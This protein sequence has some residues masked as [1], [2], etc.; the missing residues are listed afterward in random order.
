LFRAT[1]TVSSSLTVADRDNEDPGLSETIS[2]ADP[3][4]RLIAYGIL[5]FF[6]TLAVESS[7][8]ALPDV[9]MEHRLYLPGFGASAVFATLLYLLVERFTGPS[10]GKLLIPVAIIL[11]MSFGFT[12]YQRNHVWRDRVSLWQDAAAKSPDRGRTNNNLGVAL[13]KAGRTSEAIKAFSRAIEVDPYYFRTY[14]NLADIYLAEGRPELS[15]PLL[16]VYMQL[17]PDLQQGYVMYGAALMRSG[18]FPAVISFLEQNIDKVGKNAEARFY[19][20]SA[21]VFQGNREA[22]QRELKIVS[23]LDA[24]LA[25]TLAGLLGRNSQHGFSHES[26]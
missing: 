23:S 20:G 15:L 12:A 24:N 1:Q 5:W 7:F 9:I 21:Y 8:V 3:V 17:K 26:N 10:V 6:I 13:A 14:Y 25:A 18:Q 19:L 22:A 2:G 11:V 16:E 4:L